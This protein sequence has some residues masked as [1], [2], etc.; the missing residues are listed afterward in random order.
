MT[1]RAAEWHVLHPLD[2]APLAVVR[3]VQLGPRREPYYRAVTAQPDHS[4]RRLLGYWSSV[5]EA[6]EAALALF[7][8]STGRSLGGGDGRSRRG[9]PPQKPPPGPYGAGS[10]STVSRSLGAHASASSASSVSSPYAPTAVGPKPIRSLTR[11]TI[12]AEAAATA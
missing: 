6:H 5:E 9:V 10:P 12:S 8:R 11:P 4:Q 2:G 7:E 1:I 3:L